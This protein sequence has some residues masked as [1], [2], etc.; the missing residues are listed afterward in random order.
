MQSGSGRFS[1]CTIVRSGSDTRWRACHTDPVRLTDFW[2]RME[3]VLGAGYYASWA[4][5][6]VL[7]ELGGRTVNQAL[8]EGEDAKTVWLAVMANLQLPARLR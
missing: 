6:H 2:E 5:D 3:H 7:A 1:H 4:Q 8:R